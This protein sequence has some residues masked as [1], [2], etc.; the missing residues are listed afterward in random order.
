MSERCEFTRDLI[1]FS[2]NSRYKFE[3]KRI[4]F[5]SKPNACKSCNLQSIVVYVRIG[6]VLGVQLTHPYLI[7][8]FAIFIHCF[9]VLDIKA[10]SE[11][12]NI[13]I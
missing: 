6:I 5:A 2:I 12:K 10:L 1:S 3:N 13:I 7:K 8:Y 4:P 11:N 9:K